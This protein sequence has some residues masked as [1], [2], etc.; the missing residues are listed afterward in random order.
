M[1]SI[2]TDRLESMKEYLASLLNVLLVVIVCRHQLSKKL[3]L[4]PEWYDCHTTDLDQ[5]KSKNRPYDCKFCTKTTHKPT[6]H[7]MK[8]HPRKIHLMHQPYRL[9]VT[10]QVDFVG[11]IFVYCF[12]GLRDPMHNAL[13]RDD[14]IHCYACLGLTMATYSLSAQTRQLRTFDR[15]FDNWQSK[16]SGT[17]AVLSEMQFVSTEGPRWWP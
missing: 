15:T 3:R 17:S 9:Y 13:W 12:Y 4:P 5:P 8:L 1:A 6:T 2:V 10:T 16:D 11:Y 14:K 7:L